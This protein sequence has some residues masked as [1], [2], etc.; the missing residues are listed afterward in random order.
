[1]KALNRGP[2][3]N[4]PELSYLNVRKSHYVEMKFHWTKNNRSCVTRDNAIPIVHY[5]TIENEDMFEGTVKNGNIEVKNE[6]IEVLDVD[7]TLYGDNLSNDVVKNVE[8]CGD[9]NNEDMSEDNHNNDY[10]DSD[11]EM[12]NN[13]SD[14]SCKMENVEQNVDV[15]V[16]KKTDDADGSELDPE[17]AT[18]YPISKNEAQAAVEIY[19]MLSNGKYKCGTCG[20][21]YYNE[22]RLNIHLRM[23]DKVCYLLL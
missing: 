16:R 11:V 14:L 4:K 3:S 12:G 1:M 9:E 7:F 19:K 20:K 18:L 6:N 23:H 15:A 22:N 10:F 8:S 2:I 17:Y 13:L 21:P 5:T